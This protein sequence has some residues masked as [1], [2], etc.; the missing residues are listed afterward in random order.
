MLPDTGGAGLIVTLR[1]HGPVNIMV[2]APPSKSYTHRALIAAALA[3]GDSYIRYPLVSEDTLLTRA[4]LQRLGVLIKEDEEGL[5]VHGTSGELR[6]GGDV[7]LD[8][9]NSG[10]SMRLL[11]SVALLADAD[12][13]L[14]GSKRMCERPIGDLVSALNAI[15]GDVRYLGRE[16]YPPIEVSGRFCGGE[17]TID[18]AVSSQFVTSLLMA[19]PYADQ[20]L[21]L[22]LTGDP[23]SASYLDITMDVMSAFGADIRYH[24][25]G[26]FHVRS[27]EVYRGRP[28]A[29]EGDYS[30]AGYFFAI[31]AVCGGDVRVVN[32]NVTSPQGDRQLLFVLEQMGCS[33]QPVLDGYH[34]ARHGRLSGIDCDMSTMP[35]AVQTAAAVAS[36]AETETVLSGIG[37]LRYKESDRIK[38]IEQVLSMVGARVYGSDDRIRI[39]PGGLHGGVIDPADDHRTAMS[40][41]VLGLG[42]GDVTIMHAECVEKSYP[43]FWDELKEAGLWTD[44]S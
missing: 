21:S 4:A 23:V 14:T 15:G 42:I 11:A 40:G 12:V 7:V 34:L 17:V 31:G 25:P 32:L 38:A 41:A 35:D 3:D 2:S 16:G 22:R 44:M 18:P 27:K 37:H 13:V 9:G 43:A 39:V 29:V 6:P 5:V 19:G 20:D 28:Y 10:T 26:T 8:L 36:F 1:K 30:S 24:E 33:V